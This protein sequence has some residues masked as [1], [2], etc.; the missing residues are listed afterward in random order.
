MSLT[1]VIAI[2]GVASSGKT[3]VAA[4]IATTLGYAVFDSGS[5]YRSFCLHLT[6]NQVAIE[7]RAVFLAFNDFKPL[8]T[9]QGRIILAGEDVTDQ[10]HLQAI[11]DLVPVVGSAFFVRKR[12]REIQREFCLARDGKVVV[13]GRDVGKEVIPE[14][15]YKYFLQASAEARALR[16]YL[17]LMAAAQDANFD[18]ILSGLVARDGRDSTRKV[19]PMIVPQD[20]LVIDTTELKQHEVVAEILKSIREIQL[21]LEG[22]PKRSLEC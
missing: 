13:T 15:K 2:D 11:D 5:V 17:Q 1:N 8:I 14:S 16:R 7:P 21:N 20:A 12:V 6:S 4:D 3:S 18:L 9:D 10:L 22:S 19:S